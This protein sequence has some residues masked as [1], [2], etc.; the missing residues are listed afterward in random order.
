MRISLDQLISILQQQQT[1]FQASQLNVIEMMAQNLSIHKI[2]VQVSELMTQTPTTWT[3]AMM[4]RLFEQFYFSETLVTDNG[5]QFASEIFTSFL[6]KAITH[7]RSQPYHLQT[8][9]QAE[10][11][12]DTFKKALINSQGE[13]TTEVI[14]NFLRTYR[15]T[16]FPT[17]PNSIS[18][19]E[20]IFGRMI[21]TSSDSIYLQRRR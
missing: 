6:K 19:D 7:T 5:P 15:I 17:S 11:F 13:G 14:Q 9:D 10:R 3:M 21:R 4:N 1:K 20:S 2:S 18:P 16:T 12:L 8:N